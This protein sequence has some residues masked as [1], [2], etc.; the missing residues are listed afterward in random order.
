[1]TL[2]GK[3]PAAGPVRAE[4]LR[5]KVPTPTPLP[6]F[7]PPR[8]QPVGNFLFGQI[9]HGIAALATDIYTIEPKNIQLRASRLPGPGAMLNCRLVRREPPFAFTR[10]EQAAEG[11]GARNAPNAQAKGLTR[12]PS[13][14]G[15]PHWRE[16]MRSPVQ[17][18]G[19]IVHRRGKRRR[20]T[21]VAIS[22]VKRTARA[23]TRPITRGG[24]ACPRRIRRCPLTRTPRCSTPPCTPCTS[25][26]VPAWCRSRAT[27]CRCSTRPASWPSTASAA[28]RPRCS[29]CRTWAS[30]CSRAP[31]PPPRSRRW[32]RSTSSTC[33]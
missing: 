7:S 24:T 20:H 29:T 18:G 11:A 19:E 21:G 23:S 5:R 32:C 15:V 31:T 8:D 1:M 26:S 22:Q 13:N 4:R 17:A 33:R 25:N 6:L 14:T 2:L 12:R 16:T 30:C 27:R 10:K 9:L 28:T 3:Q